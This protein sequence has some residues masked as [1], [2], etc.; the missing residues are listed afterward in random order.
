MSRNGKL[1]FRDYDPYITSNFGYRIHPITG[2]NTLHTGV[3][4]GTNGKKLPTYGIED[5]NILKIGFNSGQG[6]YVYV[7]YERLGKVGLYQHLDSISVRENQNITRDTI[8]GYTGT[9]GESTGI[10]LHF[11]WFNQDEYN[12]GWYE[13]NWE[14][15]EAYE[16]T[17]PLDYLGSSI[18]RNETKD[19]IEVIIN[20]LY[21][22]KLPNGEILGY[23][24]PG[25]YNII[26]TKVSGDYTWYKIGYNM[27]IA[28]KNEFANLY[29]KKENV[30]AN[31]V[32]E[33]LKVNV[34]EVIENDVNL[35]GKDTENETF[36][37]KNLKNNFF[38][39]ILMRF[40]EF[41]Q[42]IIIFFKNM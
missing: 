29:L 28:Y 21:V 31:E 34:D 6:N 20:N 10:H 38:S 2:V 18:E 30:L 35:E 22:R 33:S 41:F 23:I 12:K 39:R 25:I 42:K 9:T 3:D 13:R 19:Q 8:I 26:D 11:G 5:G 1:L 37:D 17:K 15:F 40:R 32:E 4:Y 14:D 36:L 16:Y 7:K 27:W 24:N